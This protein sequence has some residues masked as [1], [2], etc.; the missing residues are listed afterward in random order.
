M[1]QAYARRQHKL[2]GVNLDLIMELNLIIALAFRIGLSLWLLGSGGS[3]K[4]VCA[5]HNISEASYYQ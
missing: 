5:R 3:I 2:S 1:E 4:T